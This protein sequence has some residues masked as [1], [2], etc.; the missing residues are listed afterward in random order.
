MT[1]PSAVPERCP[2][3]RT[4]IEDP[5]ADVLT[6]PLTECR[7]CGHIYVCIVTSFTEDHP[8]LCHDCAEAAP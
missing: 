3:G 7:C 1:A 6:A 8:Y 5:F 4:V 2:H